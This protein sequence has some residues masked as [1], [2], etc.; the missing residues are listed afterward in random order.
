M[1]VKRITTTHSTLYLSVFV[2]GGLKSGGMIDSRRG[3]KK[4]TPVF[5]TSTLMRFILTVC[6]G[7]GGGGHALSVYTMIASCSKVISWHIFF[8]ALTEDPTESSSAASLVG[9]LFQSV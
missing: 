8:N 4:E 3:Q 6:V 9:P 5:Q 7:V 2:K 1:V